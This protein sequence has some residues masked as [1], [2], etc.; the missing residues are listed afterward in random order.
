MK[1]MLFGAVTL[2]LLST[3]ACKKSDDGDSTPA[4]Q[5][6]VGSTTYTA[7]PVVDNS[8]GLTAVSTSN[9]NNSIGF[10]FS[11]GKPT[12]NGTYTVSSTTGGA[13]SVT[14]VATDGT[15]MGAYYVKSGTV[16]VTVTNGK[17]NVSLPASPAS[18]VGTDTK[19]DADVS[20]NITE[21]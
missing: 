20:A 8:V 3:A 21:Q 1:K 10:V 9:G 4:N 5:W 13:G 18:Y 16:T 17:L 6:K 7:S 15:T 19:P 14:V 11:G 2:A 12:T